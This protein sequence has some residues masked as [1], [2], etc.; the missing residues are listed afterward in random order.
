MSQLKDRLDSLNAEKTK[1][2]EITTMSTTGLHSDESKMKC[3]GDFLQ[4]L[5][6]SGGLTY[7]TVILSYK[8]KKYEEILKLVNSIMMRPF[9]QESPNRIGFTRS[10]WLHNTPK[11]MIGIIGT[12]LEMKKGPDSYIPMSSSGSP[13]N[14]FL[15]CLRRRMEWLINK[16]L[17]IKQYDTFEFNNQKLQISQ[18]IDE[19]TNRIPVETDIVM[20]ENAVYHEVT[21]DD[22]QTTVLLG[23]YAKK[24]PI[25][26]NP[27]VLASSSMLLRIFLSQKSSA[28]ALLRIILGKEVAFDKQKIILNE[29]YVD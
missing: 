20:L 8:Y 7:G 11:T 27:V 14:I 24:N 4:T 29:I 18:H 3:I 10:F 1:I 2:D 17:F 21:R 13:L 6:T 23:N 26:D 25:T 15:E 16:T 22:N 28:T 12:H 9:D 19:S 5:F